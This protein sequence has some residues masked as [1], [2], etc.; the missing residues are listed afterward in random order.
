MNTAGQAT[1]VSVAAKDADAAQMAF[2]TSRTS[3][4]D[5]RHQLASHGDAEMEGVSTPGEM[6]LGDHTGGP[7]LA[8]FLA[9]EDNGSAIS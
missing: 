7:V 1:Q 8:K 6:G 2:A 3:P 5:A 9:K 4:A